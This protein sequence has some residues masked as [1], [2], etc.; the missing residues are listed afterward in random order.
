MLIPADYDKLEVLLRAFGAADHLEAVHARHPDVGNHQV[1]GERPDQ[2]QGFEAV[3][4]RP[5]DFHIYFLPIDKVLNQ[6]ADFF[7]V[8]RYHDSNH[9]FSFPGS[10]PC[11]SRGICES[12]A[13]PF[14]L[15]APIQIL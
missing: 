9:R 5:H 10:A 7:L 6:L 1:G 8:V 15:F 12:A 4:R 3:P 11:G 13:K 2:V 14:G